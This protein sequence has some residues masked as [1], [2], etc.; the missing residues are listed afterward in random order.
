MLSSITLF[1]IYMIDTTFNYIDILTKYFYRIF[2]NPQNEIIYFDFETTGLNPYH[3][4]IIEYAFLSECYYDNLDENNDVFLNTPIDEISK[5]PLDGTE[6]FIN[7]LV[8]PE[9]KFEKKITEITN[10]HPEDLEN[11]KS[12]DEHIPIIENFINYND[13]NYDKIPYLVAHNCDSFDK[14]FLKTCIKEYEEN[15]TCVDSKNWRYID[16]LSLSKKVLPNIRSYSLK[17]LSSHFNV[18]PGTHRALSDT[19]CLK[20]VFTEL[21]KL[22]ADDLEHS[23]EYLMKNPEIIYN[24]IYN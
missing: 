21:V 12:I 16:T 14:I 11:K 5:R 1:T 18:D 2:S 22:V 20:K 23:Y 15:N 24:Y 4:K 10:I 19:V 17:S 13:T 8:N 6:N 7:E 9:I 3:D